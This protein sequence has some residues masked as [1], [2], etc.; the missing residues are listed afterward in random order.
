MCRECP[1]LHRYASSYWMAKATNMAS[2]FHLGSVPIE[3]VAHFVAQQSTILYH[4]T[5]NHCDQKIRPRIYIHNR[6]HGNG[7]FFVQCHNVRAFQLL[8]SKYL[9]FAS[10]LPIFSK[11]FNSCK[12]I[13]SSL[14]MVLMCK[15]C[16]NAKKSL[17]I[18]VY[19]FF[20]YRI[21]TLRHTILYLDQYTTSYSTLSY[22]S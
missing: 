4:R 11:I 15:Y 1:Q 10:E 9:S 20:R 14:V 21:R 16:F 3:I 22:P 18:K 17:M 2:L 6:D 7:L 8:L 12:L 13:S 19:R 5:G